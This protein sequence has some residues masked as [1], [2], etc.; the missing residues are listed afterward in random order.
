MR[1]LLHRI[2][3]VVGFPLLLLSVY[4][5]TPFWQAVSAEKSAENHVEISL[6]VICCFSLVAFHNFYLSLIFV[7][8][9]NMCLSMF[10][11]EFILYMI[12]CASW[13][14]TFSS[15]VRIVFC[16]NMLKYFLR[17]FLFLFSFCDI[18]NVN[19]HLFNVEPDIFLEIF[20]ILFQCFFFFSVFFSVTVFSTT[21][22]SNSLIPFSASIIVIHFFWCIFHFNYFI[23]HLCL[24]FT[25]Y[26]SF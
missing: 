9:I 2:C 23:I 3:L 12:L 24:L 14:C 16:Y 19:V 26:S 7:G 22:F 18:Y 17:P 20:F 13:T 10:L 1:I 21:L 6:Y 8:L 4:H 15:Y 5:A 11:L 25:L